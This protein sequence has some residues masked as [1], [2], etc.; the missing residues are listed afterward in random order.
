ME[1][2]NTDG[3]EL[4]KIDFDSAAT[5]MSVQQTHPAMY[6]EDGLYCCLLGP[7]PEAGIF[8]RGKSPAEAMA[9]FDKHFQS[10]LEHPVNGDPVS[11]FIHNRH[12]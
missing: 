11:D 2:M 7:N 8:G 3:L 9:E 1:Q 10:L 6:L 4:V 5:P 12:I